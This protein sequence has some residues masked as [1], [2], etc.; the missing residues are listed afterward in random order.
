MV[1][2]VR[3]PRAERPGKP[4]G[5]DLNTPR[6]LSTPPKHKMHRKSGLRQNRADEEAAVWLEHS[7]PFPN[8][9]DGARFCISSP[10]SLSSWRYPLRLEQIVRNMRAS[11]LSDLAASQN[12][13]PGDVPGV[14]GATVPQ[15]GVPRSARRSCG[16]DCFYLILTIRYLHSKHLLFT[17]GSWPHAW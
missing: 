16:Y 13:V 4:I 1:W 7:A 15:E 6:H 5:L 9:S 12:R 2:L 17:L 14:D 11:S 10:H 8:P 3:H